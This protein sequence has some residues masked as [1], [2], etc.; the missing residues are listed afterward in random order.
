MAE[1][2]K[3]RKKIHVIINENG[4]S[5]ASRWKSGIFSLI[6]SRFTIMLVLFCIQALFLLLVWGFFGELLSKIS[7]YG[8]TI[9]G[10]VVLIYLLNT[11]MDTSGKITWMLVIAVFPVFGSMF[12]FWTRLELGHRR[13]RKRLDQVIEGSRGRL[14]QNPET[15]DRLMKA[16]R[17]SA[18]VARYTMLA[19][20]FPAYENSRVT[21]YSDGE[22]KLQALILEL[23]KAQKFIF[24]EYFIIQEGFMWGKVLEVLNEKVK[25]GVEVRVMFDGMCQFSKVPMDYKERMQ[26]IGIDALIWAPIVPVVTTSYNYRDHRKIVVIDGKVAFTG[27]VNLA[28]EYINRGSKFGYWKDTAVR[29]EGDAVMSFTY[30]FLTMWYA[31]SGI[32]QDFEVYMEETML[33]EKPADSRGFVIPYGD[34]P[35]DN[36]KVGEMVYI[37]IL[38][39]AEDYVYIMTPYLILDGEL[40]TALR[41]AAER[42]VD[43]RI[44]LPGIPDKKLVY[45]LAKNQCRSLLASGVKIYFFKPGFVHAKVFVS[46]DRK[47]VV[48]TINLDYRSL[49]HHFE[50]AVYMVDQPCVEEIKDDFDQ[51]CFRCVRVTPELLKKDS[52]ISRLNGAIAKMIAPIL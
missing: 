45:D 23:K 25:E 3:V 48:G 39:T 9:F 43:V 15:A 20:N 36:Y 32:S 52:I 14:V 10:A 47:A 2:K 40:E 27:G 31:A 26:A 30:M 38:N 49:Y 21:Y 22:K 7:A 51:T 41:F 29:V 13:T 6:F 19:G 35:L 46:D 44:I 24:L 4:M 37:D 5:L 11:D 28:D 12:Y 33:A 17:D 50:D 42:G 18:S 8:Q 16:D 34:S 1:L